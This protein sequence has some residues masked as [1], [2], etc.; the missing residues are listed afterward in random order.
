[1]EGGTMF[2]RSELRLQGL[3]SGGEGNGTGE[4]M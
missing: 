4:G 1:M 3:G 2:R